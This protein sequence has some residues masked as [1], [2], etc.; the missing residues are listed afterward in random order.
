MITIDFCTYKKYIF[1]TRAISESS[2]LIKILL[3]THYASLFHFFT[4]INQDIPSPVLGSIMISVNHIN[5]Y[6]WNLSS[7]WCLKF[8]GITPYH[9]GR[10]FVYYLYYFQFYVTCQANPSFEIRIKH[11]YVDRS[12]LAHHFNLNRFTLSCKREFAINKMMH[13]LYWGH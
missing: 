6:H 12:Y 10:G 4:Y 7:A 8:V 13:Y 5:I 9:I 1:R 3:T 2:C 11:G